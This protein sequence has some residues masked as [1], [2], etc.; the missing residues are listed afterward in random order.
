MI[1]K[2]LLAALTFTASTSVG[3]QTQVVP[4]EAAPTA[5]PPAPVS[6]DTIPIKTIVEIEL[7]EALS[8]N[9]SNI[10]D[11]FGL[12]LSTPLTIDGKTIL[13]AGLAGRGEVTHAAKSG[14]GGKAGELIIN[15]RYLQCGAVRV[16]LGHFHYSIAGKNNVTGAFATAQFVPFGQFLVSGHEAVIPA[17]ASG[18]AQV[19]AEVALPAGASPQCGP[20]VK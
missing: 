3:A 14:W 11:T 16:P 17:G 18:T 2:A 10:G 1:Q 7:T 6:A 12:K 19:N 5:Q 20:E 15:A 8:S 13:P 4:S 9:T